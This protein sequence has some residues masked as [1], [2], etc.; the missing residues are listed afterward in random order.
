MNELNLTMPQ[1]LTFLAVVTPFTVM[2]WAD[3]LRVRPEERQTFL[4]L[5]EALESEAG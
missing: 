2:A 5:L 3:L 1:L 4:E